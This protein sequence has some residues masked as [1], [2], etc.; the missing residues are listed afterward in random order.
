MRQQYHSRSVGTDVLIWDVKRLVQ[1]VQD[2]PVISISLMNLAELD[3]NWWFSDKHDAPTPRALAAHMQ[4]V[5]RADLNHPIILCAEG[6]LM[7]GMHRAVKALL[8]GND[9]VRAVQF[10]RTPPPDHVNVALEDLPYDD[11]EC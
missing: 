8:D 4:L 2:L 9:A 11:G 1:L 10:A 5:L 3:E 6:R 7:D